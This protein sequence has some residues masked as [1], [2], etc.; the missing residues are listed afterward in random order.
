[1]FGNLLVAGVTMSVT[2]KG[3]LVLVIA[4]SII[5]TNLSKVLAA[6]ANLTN[7]I[8]QQE[9][10][11]RLLE[12]I[13]GQG[14][15]LPS[16]FDID[17][18][19]DNG[20]KPCI[21]SNLYCYSRFSDFPC[22]GTDRAFCSIATC[23]YQN[24]AHSTNIPRLIPQEIKWT[25]RSIADCSLNVS[26]GS[27]LFEESHN[28]T[29]CESA[30]QARWLPKALIN[31]SASLNHTML[32][33]MHTAPP[34]DAIEA[35]AITI[36][37]YSSLGAKP[38]SITLY[39]NSTEVV[40]TTSYYLIEHYQEL[41]SLNGSFALVLGATGQAV[42]FNGE[43]AWT[44]FTPDNDSFSLIGVE[45]GSA[46]FRGLIA[47]VSLYAGEMTS[48]EIYSMHV[49]KEA[50]KPLLSPDCECPSW[51]TDSYGLISEAQGLYPDEQHCYS[52]INRTRSLPPQ[53]RYFGSADG[54][55]AVFTPEGWMSDYTETTEILIK[56]SQPM[57]I[58]SVL[59]RFASK[60]L[61][62]F[63][64]LK[65]PKSMEMKIVKNSEI[66]MATYV[67][68]DCMSDYGLSA[69]GFDQTI[70]W[71]KN[72][73]SEESLCFLWDLVQSVNTRDFLTVPFTMSLNWY[74][75]EALE[76]DLSIK[77]IGHS[78]ATSLS[79]RWH[80]IK[81]LTLIT[82]PHCGGHNYILADPPETMSEYFSFRSPESEAYRCI[83]PEG[84]YGSRCD[85]CASIY[86]YQD[87][88]GTCINCSCSE[89][90]LSQKC[91][92]VTG[93][94]PCSDGIDLHLAGPKCHW[95]IRSISPLYGPIA[96]GTNI[97]ATGPYFSSANITYNV[98][99]NG[100]ILP[101][102]ARNEVLTFLTP[103]YNKSNSSVDI[104]IEAKSVL[105]VGPAKVLS[106]EYRPNPVLNDIQPRVTILSGGTNLT[107][108]GTSL[109][110]VAKPLLLVRAKKA[111]D[112]GPSRTFTSECVV[113][114]DIEMRCTTPDV[115]SI[116][117]ENGDEKVIPTI[118]PTK[119]ANVNSSEELNV[120]L[121]ANISATDTTT[122]MLTTNLANIFGRK[123]RSTNSGCKNI[124]NLLYS[125]GLKLDAY[126]SYQDLASFNDSIGQKVQIYVY[127]DPQLKTF[128]ESYGDRIQEYDPDLN[129]S[130]IISGDRMNCGVN[131]DDYTVIIGKAMCTVS[132]LAVNELR[133]T[134]P[135]DQPEVAPNI[136]QVYNKQRIPHVEVRVG[137]NAKFAV[138]SIY[139][140]P[141]PWKNNETLQIGVISTLSVVGVAV[142]VIAIV[143][144]VKKYLMKGDAYILTGPVGYYPANRLRKQP[145]AP[146]STPKQMRGREEISF[147]SSKLDPNIQAVVDQCRLAPERLRLGKQLGKGNFGLV[148]K[149]QFVTSAGNLKT[150]AVKSI[151]DDKEM[152]LDDLESFLTEGTL[153]INFKH[154]NVLSLIGV[155]MEEG[156][157]PLVVLPYMEHA[158][159]ATFIKTEEVELLLA[160][161]L[162]FAFQIANGMAYLAR[163][164]FVHRDLAARNCMLDGAY[165]VKIADFGLSRDIYEK[166]YYR[167]QDQSKPMPVRWM[168]LE[169]FTEGKYTSKSD[170][171]AYGITL[172]ELL[173]RGGIPYP[174]INNYHISE[175]IASGKRI[176]KPD[177]CPSII[178][179]MMR[180]CW[181]AEPENRPSFPDMSARL[182]KLLKGEPVSNDRATE[183]PAFDRER[184]VTKNIPDDY[185]DKILSNPDDEY[186]GPDAASDDDSYVE[187]LPSTK[188]RK[189]VN[190]Y[191]P[192][193]IVNRLSVLIKNKSASGEA[194]VYH[195]DAPAGYAERLNSY[196][197]RTS[198]S[199]VES[200]VE[201]TPADG[202]MKTLDLEREK[203][204]T[205]SNKPD[206][207]A[208]KDIHKSTAMADLDGNAAT[209]IYDSNPLT[210]SDADENTSMSDYDNSPLLKNADDVN[211]PAKINIYV[212]TSTLKDADNM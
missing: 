49:K 32:F 180:E 16:H 118:E 89:L 68:E 167:L 75:D 55:W 43:I 104:T 3:F 122:P 209:S 85:E 168:A 63:D 41:Q 181:D 10:L 60:Y 114:S 113:I 160:D 179:E 72:E 42:Y 29:S 151:K 88:Q 102:S 133:C 14:R 39:L 97:T 127:E 66:K 103:S 172:W 157:R 192:A 116:L 147:P 189:F 138:G 108:T 184:R 158:D 44:S 57:L 143:V 169:C 46:N 130:L 101:A 128:E 31:T 206:D 40:N 124:Q 106:F 115:T 186:A 67:T 19:T 211:N 183:T 27:L 164:K 175:Y 13:S 119:T 150:V 23:S 51:S 198:A 125:L 91:E 21:P 70:R 17:I 135:A 82:R 15:R 28:S 212:N 148:L 163:E 73:S 26:S 1:M 177:I 195:K 48:S 24:D 187:V 78:T 100:T 84:L 202:F 139:Y 59:G 194:V 54:R 53:P 7:S 155:V 166:A 20:Y 18:I 47:N 92:D 45:F 36:T 38:L 86:M 96:G 152:T 159:L 132:Y 37:G 81:D 33:D 4:G 171:W 11:Y 145:D 111:D 105:D 52:I 109:S 80:S 136:Y 87:E 196:A 90:S 123:R 204:K 191:I 210:M 56:F 205:T 185:L 176:E 25:G 121:E 129:P 207:T 193:K 144:L 69:A 50:P 65:R 188:K 58:Y 134:P 35:H 140:K 203:D 173:T 95:Y 9:E 137:A 61:Q 190:N 83:C 200:P 154:E 8:D 161:L 142:I 201:Y 77:L 79:E 74:F 156:E 30:L 107:M 126:T 165:I 22:N 146:D 12:S 34:T 182:D 62:S 110:S 76:G 71:Y 149:G 112:T 93:N 6:A 99:M 117:F 174:G 94:C 178:Y 131:M 208:A 2:P 5:T 162:H 153:M 141:K 170:V 120:T 64:G 197:D 98:T 199:D